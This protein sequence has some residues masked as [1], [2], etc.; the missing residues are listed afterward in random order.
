MRSTRDDAD[1]APR[2]AD[3]RPMT[4]NVACFGLE[5]VEVAPR[6]LLLHLRER[7]ATDEVALGKLDRPAE[8]RL[9]GV[10]RLVH[11]VSVQPQRGFEAGGVPRAETGGQHALR[12]ALG[13]DGVPGLSDSSRLDEQLET[14]LSRVAGTRDERGNAGDLAGPKC[15]IWDVIG[16][17]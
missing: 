9:I 7:I 14:V 11:D 4:W 6:P 3:G 16:R 8:A 10:D 17:R 5:T 15:E 1:S 2:V 12:V 13:E